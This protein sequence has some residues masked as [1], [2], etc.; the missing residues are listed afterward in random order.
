MKNADIGLSKLEDKIGYKF[1]NRK[2]LKI[3]LTHS[4]FANESEGKLSSYERLEFLGDSIL[5][6][7][8]S[9]YIFK[10]FPNYPEGDLTKLRASLVCE[11]QLCVFS[12][13]LEIGKFLKLSRGE[14][15]SGGRERASILADIFE[16]ICAAIYLDSGLTESSKFILKFIVPALKHPMLPDIHDYKTDLQEIVQKN[17]E[18]TIEYVLIKEVGPDHDKRFT[19][20]ARINSNPVG[21]GI[22]KSKK[23]AEQ[24]A[25]RETLKLMGY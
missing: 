15:H 25:A 4:S 13:E 6:L 18:E 2:L 21:V 5:G 23:E 7:V 20:E 12:K 14:Q 24:H 16:S 11:K 10:N 9:D 3:A 22:G 8:T 17:P 1:K 19:M